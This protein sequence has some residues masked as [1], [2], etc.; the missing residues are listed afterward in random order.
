MRGAVQVPDLTGLGAGLLT[1]GVVLG[2]AAIGLIMLGGV[3]L[4][5]RHTELPPQ[6]PQRLAPTTVAT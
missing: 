2:P 1:A 3:G 4:S 5:R 6:A